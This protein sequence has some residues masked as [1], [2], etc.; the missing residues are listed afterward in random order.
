MNITDTL[1][2]NP[3]FV[4]DAQEGRKCAR[5]LR[6]DHCAGMDASVRRV[7]A[8]AALAR[9]MAEHEPV[10]VKEPA[11]VSTWEPSATTQLGLPTPEFFKSA[12]SFKIPVSL[13]PDADE[14]W[15]LGGDFAIISD[16]HVPYHK[17]SVLEKFCEEAYKANIRRF[18]I[19]GDTNDCGQF[20]PKRG[21]MQHHTRRF[22][23]DLEITK[24]IF[25]VFMQC[26][27]EGGFV[28]EGN[29]DGWL[30]GH[31]RG[32]ILPDFAYSKFFHEYPLIKFSNFEQCRIVSGEKTI[33]ALHGSQY[34]ATSPLSVAQGLATKFEEGIVMGHQ[35]AAA[36]GWSR[37]GKHQTICLGGAYDLKKLAY[38]H[39]SPRSNPTPTNGFALLKDG[40][41]KAYDDPAGFVR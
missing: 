37:S 1:L 32:Q 21:H 34:S 40:Y 10:A 25:G 16:L 6:F 13:E 36:T 41:L 35:H 3:S 19:I 20:H 15:E 17:A 31:L 14:F 12:P 30:A 7:R 18:L 11:T 28:L 5:D 2:S 29:H 26:F 23:D 22:Q 4:K 38:L 9:T 8:V 39:H 24:S 33:R 27:P